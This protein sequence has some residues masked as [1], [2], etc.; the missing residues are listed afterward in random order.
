D[1]A[2]DGAVPEPMGAQLERIFPTEYRHTTNL[3]IFS[4]M[5][6]KLIIFEKKF[7]VAVVFRKFL[8]LTD[9]NNKTRR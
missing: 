6:T 2:I 7:P 1:D 8:R 9:R 3:P 5:P 4:A